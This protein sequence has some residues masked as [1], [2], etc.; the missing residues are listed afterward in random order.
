MKYVSEMGSGAVIYIPGFMKIGSG[1]QILIGEGE[2]QRQH[3]DLI[4]L[5]LFFSELGK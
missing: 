3:G 2:T 4:V 1:L 5:L